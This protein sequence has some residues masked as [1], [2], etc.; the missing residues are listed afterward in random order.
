MVQAR[1]DTFH[2]LVVHRKT[3]IAQMSCARFTT[4]GAPSHVTL[5]CSAMRVQKRQHVWTVPWPGATLFRRLVGRVCGRS[6]RVFH[7]I[8]GS[9]PTSTSVFFSQV[10]RSP[11]SRNSG[12]IMPHA[13]GGLQPAEPKRGKLQKCHDC[14]SPGYPSRCGSRC[15]GT[16]QIRGSGGGARGTGEEINAEDGPTELCQLQP[17]AVRARCCEGRRSVFQR[18]RGCAMGCRQNNRCHAHSRCFFVCSQEKQRARA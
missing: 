18:G 11:R 4:A 8:E 1:I 15:G 17:A 2:A 7:A 10:E 3:P 6:T 14:G 12:Q 13:H 9:T 16:R 5:K